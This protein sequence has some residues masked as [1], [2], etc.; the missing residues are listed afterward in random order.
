MSRFKILA[1]ILYLISFKI[2]QGQTIRNYEQAKTAVQPYIDT[3]PKLPVNNIFNLHWRKTKILGGFPKTLTCTWLV[4]TMRNG[5]IRETITFKNSNFIVGHIAMYDKKLLQASISYQSS[6]D[7]LG[8]L[9]DT[10]EH[11]YKI[12]HLLISI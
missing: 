9:I 8:R 6:A 12:P 2:M 4:K 1:L 7:T 10:N 11:D 3:V 5:S